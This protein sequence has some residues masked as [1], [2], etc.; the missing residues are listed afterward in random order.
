MTVTRDSF[1]ALADEFVVRHCRLFLEIRDLYREIADLLDEK[2]LVMEE[3]L[4][5]VVGQIRALWPD[6][7][8][9]KLRE[10]DTVLTA[11]RDHYARKIAEA[12]PA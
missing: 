12:E 8:E 10:G 4:P 5:D 2:P 3:P 7:S 6:D 9:H 1:H 11:L